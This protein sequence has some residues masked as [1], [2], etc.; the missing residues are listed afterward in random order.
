MES[1]EFADWVTILRSTSEGIQKKFLCTTTLWWLCFLYSIK[2]LPGPTTTAS[3]KF[4]RST[5]G[6]HQKNMQGKEALLTAPDKK[7]LKGKFGDNFLYNSFKTYV[8]THHYCLIETVLIR[9]H[10]I[11]FHWEIRKFIFG[12]SSIPPLIWSSA[13]CII[14]WSSSNP[15]LIMLTGTLSVNANGDNPVCICCTIQA[16]YPLRTR[17]ICILQNSLEKEKICL[18]KRLIMHPLASNFLKREILNPPLYQRG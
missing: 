18:Q 6:C 15:Q 16:W 17:S 1:Y 2:I 5:T 3:D 9:D 14:M 13:Y 11:C 8:E 4:N 12:L 10:H 7:W